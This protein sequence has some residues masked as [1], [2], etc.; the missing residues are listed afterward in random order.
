M[1]RALP[2]VPCVDGF[3]TIQMRDIGAADLPMISA[4]EVRQLTSSPVAT[5]KAPVV[6]PTAFSYEIPIPPGDYEA[7][8][9]FAEIL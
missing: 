3:L 2:S 5:T 7:V 4:I 9:H 8:F 6:P 1:T